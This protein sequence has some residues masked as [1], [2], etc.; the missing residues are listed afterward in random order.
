MSGIVNQTLAQLLEAGAPFGSRQLAALTGVSRQA[1]HKHLRALVAQGR[2]VA[3]GRARAVRYTPVT[4]LRQ[5]VEVASAGSRY[6]LSARLL[7]LEVQAGEV[8]VDF[9]GVTELGDE[10]LE[11]LFLVWAPAHPAVTLKVAHL[12]SKLALAFFAFARRSTL[13]DPARARP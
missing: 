2:L 6:R 1:V 7:M 13:R 4:P 3:S 12:P 10:F 5:R 8:T 11:E 9:T